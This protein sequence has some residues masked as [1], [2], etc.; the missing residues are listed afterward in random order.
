MILI[1][2]NNGFTL[3]E[4]LVVMAVAGFLLFLLFSFLISGF[5]N[6]KLGSS[7]A[8]RQD[9]IRLVETVL[10]NEL[11]NAS[12]I[13]ISAYETEDSCDEI[14]GDELNISLTNNLFYQN[15][16]KVSDYEFDDI[17]FEVIDSAPYSFIKFTL[18][19]ID[20]EREDYEI[21]INLNNCQF[22]STTSSKISLSNNNLV[23]KK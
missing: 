21:K 8:E 17:T 4:L 13:K 23:Y 18:S 10:T 1:K 22:K 14:S 3:V 16:R 7:R 5:D 15:G 6:F 2:K 20:G 19:F 11:R 12:C 9:A